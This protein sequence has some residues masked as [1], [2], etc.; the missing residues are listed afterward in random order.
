MKEEIK[1]KNLSMGLLILLAF[2][3]AISITTF[4]SLIIWFR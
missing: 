1:I 3:S 2:I 4:L